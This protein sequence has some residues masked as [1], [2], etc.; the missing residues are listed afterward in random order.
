MTY[1][2]LSQYGKLRKQDMCGPYSMFCKLIHRWKAVCSPAEV[3]SH[4]SL[5]VTLVG[6][7]Y[8]QF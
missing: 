1:D 5:T 4:L 8:L 2:E 6:G 3:Q 7:H